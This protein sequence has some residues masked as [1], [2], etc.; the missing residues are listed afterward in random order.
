MSQPTY[1]IQFRERPVAR[2]GRMLGK[3]A[4]LRRALSGEWAGP[5][6]IIGGFTDKKEADRCTSS[7]YN[8]G[9]VTGVKFRTAVIRDAKTD[10]YSVQVWKKEA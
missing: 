3:W 5:Y 7:V 8:E 2:V 4:A 10:S 6:M 1:T 9:I